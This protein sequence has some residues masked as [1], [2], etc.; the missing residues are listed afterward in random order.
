MLLFVLF[1]IQLNR[2]I[3]GNP[4]FQLHVI[5]F[6]HL[7]LS[8]SSCSACNHWPYERFHQFHIEFFSI[9]ISYY[10]ETYS[11]SSLGKTL[12]PMVGRKPQHVV[13]KLPCLVLSSAISCRSSIC[14]GRLSTAWLVSLV[15]FSCHM[16]SK[17]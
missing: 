17:W 9:P 12:C 14:P 6:H 16:V 7:S 5:F 13:S 4:T 15:V 3:F 2:S 11:S 10:N 1:S 8:P